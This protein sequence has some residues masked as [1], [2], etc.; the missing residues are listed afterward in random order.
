VRRAAAQLDEERVDRVGHVVQVVVEQAVG[1]ARGR[2]PAA[3]RQV[4]HAHARERDPLEERG[5]VEPE[6]PGVRVEVVQ[7]EQQVDVRGRGRVRDPVGL[8]PVAQGIDER[9]DVLEQRRRAHDGAGPRDVARRALDGLRRPGRRRQVADLDAAAAHEREVLGPE[10]GLDLAH[11]AR[12]ALQPPLVD[13][14]GRGEA[15]RDAVEHDR[16][17]GGQRAQRAQLR[18][19]GAEVVVGDDLDEVDAVRVREHARPPAPA[20]SRGRRDRSRLAPA[21]AAASAASAAPQDEPQELDEPQD[22]DEAP[23]ELEPPEA[24]ARGKNSC[25]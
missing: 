6:V 17:L 7:V 16:H 21:S 13:R 4:D 11:D 8:A 20:A 22:E 23:H 5:R 12:D 1:A 18:A 10:L 3:A 15:E 2:D 9:G 19:R 14:L 24:A 25:A